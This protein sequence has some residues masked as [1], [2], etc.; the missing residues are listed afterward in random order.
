MPWVNVNSSMLC[1]ASLSNTGLKRIADQVLIWP[2]AT[3][4]FNRVGKRPTY[5]AEQTQQRARE[6]LAFI[7]KQFV[8]YGVTS[9]HHEG[10]DLFALQQVRARGELLHRVSYEANG[11]VLE[12]MIDGGIQ[13]GFGD[14]WLRF[15]AT[16]E[17]TVDGSFSERT[18]ALS[19]P[20][21]GVTPPYNGNVTETQAELDAWIERVHRA[22]IQVNC[23]ANGD[24]AIDI[25]MVQT[26]VERAQKV[27]PRPD[28]RPK[29]THCTQVNDD[30]VR[31]IKA[32]GTVPAAF[33]TYAYYNSDKFKYYGE[34]MMSIAW[35]IAPSSMPGLWRRQVRTSVRDRLT[36]GWPFREWSRGRGGMDRRGAP[37]SGSACKRRCR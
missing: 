1:S 9:V 14:E 35:P 21:P 7:S 4:P 15:G 5:T 13:T 6:G 32:T 22:G 8:R 2:F 3:D 17:H 31:R 33:T 36:R 26:A 12:A 25:D 34:E 19:T 20:Y 18:M 30:L 27:F 11:R 37:T 10:G 16:A 28:A 24:V 23:H 29:I